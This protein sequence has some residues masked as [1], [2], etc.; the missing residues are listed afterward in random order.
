LTGGNA[1]YIDKERV[2]IEES[3]M[4]RKMIMMGFAMVA[5]LPQSLYANSWDKADQ[6]QSYSSWN[7][8]YVPHY[9]AEAEA[10]PLMDHLALP[11]G[12][13]RHS[14]SSW[15]LELTPPRAEA[16]APAYPL[17]DRDKRIGFGMR[18]AF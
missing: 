16:A 10:H 17:M 3:I 14:S 7:T 8:P 5:G 12:F 4:K 1:G 15:K 18:L 6:T 9:N 13:S 11:A 2:F